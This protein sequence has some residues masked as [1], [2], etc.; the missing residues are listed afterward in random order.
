MQ[1]RDKASKR[2][3]CW[4]RTSISVCEDRTEGD[5]STV[6]EGTWSKARETASANEMALGGGCLMVSASE[7]DMELGREAA[8]GSSW[9]DVKLA[10]D[11][12]SALIGAADRCLV[13]ELS[14]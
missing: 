13:G 10:L 5:G 8:V 14:L 6:G 7:R 12:G 2:S 11:P 4:A 1:I 9:M 3:C